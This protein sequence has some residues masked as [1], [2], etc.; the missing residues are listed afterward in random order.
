MYLLG[1]NTATNTAPEM[2]IDNA[3]TIMAHAVKTVMEQNGGALPGGR[4]D[5]LGVGGTLIRIYGANGLTIGTS[6]IQFTVHEAFRRVH[7]DASINKVGRLGKIKTW[8]EA[9]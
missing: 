9:T 2:T 5:V 7:F 8:T 3:K 1:M 6:R 4:T